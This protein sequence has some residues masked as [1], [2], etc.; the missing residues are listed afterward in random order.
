MGIGEMLRVNGEY[1]IP[2][3]RDAWAGIREIDVG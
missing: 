1:K 2:I 3:L